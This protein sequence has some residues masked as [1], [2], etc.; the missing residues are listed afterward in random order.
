MKQLE[1]VKFIPLRSAKFVTNVLRGANLDFFNLVQFDLKT[2]QN[3]NCSDLFEK[4]SPQIE[5]LIPFKCTASLYTKT[6]TRLPYL[7]RLI[8]TNV[9]YLNRNW[10]CEINFI[11][12]SSSLLYDLIESNQE[13]SIN[14]DNE[15]VSV[16]VSVDLKNTL[17][18][19]DNLN[20]FRVNQL[21][22]M[23]AFHVHTKEIQLP[24]T[25]SSLYLQNLRLK[26]QKA[27]SLGEHF[28]LIVYSTEQLHSHFILS[29]NCPTLIQIKPLLVSRAPLAAQA[30]TEFTSS[31]VKLTFDIVTT[32]EAFDLS[33][34]A[35]VLQEQNGKLY[36]Q[37]TNSLTQ[38]TEQVPVKFLFGVGEPTLEFKPVVTPP[39]KREQSL[40]AYLFGWI[41]ELTPN[42]ITSFAIMLS[43]ALI[44]ILIIL[45]TKPTSQ[46]TA[47][48]MAA[49][50]AAAA[51]R[52]RS[53]GV[54]E[55]SSFNP[56]RYFTGAS[57][58]YRQDLSSSFHG[59]PTSPSSFSFMSPQ[60]TSSGGSPLKRSPQ[61]QS[62]LSNDQLLSTSL[63][64][65]QTNQ[66]VP[67][68]RSPRFSPGAAAVG[69]HA[70]RLFSVDTDVT[71]T[72]PS[73]F[74]DT[75]TNPAYHSRF[76]MDD[77]Y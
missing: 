55:R 64:S 75:T 48:E 23:P 8:K 25:R 50:A 36:V 60:Q 65:Y 16:K 57:V 74:F 62:Y 76:N 13:R 71:N 10:N 11:S 33:Q 42:Q 37:I 18:D 34:Y 54:K 61:K 1:K 7:D 32:E 38:Q 40:L 58:P 2:P 45:R 41:F 72:S 49:A 39:T 9:K 73:S 77:N 17:T 4:I 52:A 46:P 3:Q 15:P 35:N 68:I 12:G 31:V 67:T 20:E 59:A 29:T 26:N 43:L 56:Y 22:F 21:P 63:P 28:N 30:S 51:L 14:N 47:H 27:Y 24:I 66:N 44:T 19:M 53:S 69:D 6:G 70:V 5:H